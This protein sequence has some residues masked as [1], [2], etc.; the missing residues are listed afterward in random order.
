MVEDER[1]SSNTGYVLPLI[2]WLGALLALR[3]AAIHAATIDLVPDEAQYWSWSQELSFGYFSKPPMIAWLIRGATAVCG[4]GA[5]CIRSPSSVLYTL[6]SAMAFLTGRAL[7][8][9]RVG[10]WSAVVFDTLPGL[11]YSSLL[12]TTDVPL[13]L[14][15]TVALYFWV[16][17][18]KRQTMGFAVLFGIAVGLGLLTKQ[19]M[20][21]AFLCVACHALISR[22]ARE[23]LKG[24]RGLIAVFV[25]LA[26]LAPNIVWNAEHGF[27]TVRHTGANI[28]WQYPYIHPLQ[29]LDYVLVQFGVFGPILVV[30]L[31]RTAWREI[32]APGDERKALLLCFSLPVLA[33]L[34]V[35]AVLSRTH[36]N[37]SA[38]AYPA[39]TILVTAVLLELERKLLFAVSLGLH[40]AIAVL[41]AIAPAFARQWPLFERV[42]FL[43]QAVGWRSAADAVRA[44]LD[45]DRY[46]ALL[47]DTRETAAELLY[48]LRDSKVPLYVWRSQAAPSNHYEMTR[49]YGAG[50]PEPVL[51][52][53][54]RSCPPRSLT[55]AFAET[56]ELGATTVPLVKDKARVLHFC[57]LAGYKGG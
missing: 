39:A 53:S 55:Q 1:T 40:L 3:L 22:E 8:N 5:V 46:G 50:A 7:F 9:A 45:E 12:I 38:T 57:R 14:F 36:G 31:I 43:S 13:I 37:W 29:L 16:M 18:V 19:A 23:A 33:I 32:T 41:L 27:P 42:Q 24:G 48:Y 2:A 6:A 30:V 20:L 15:W 56:T 21:Y 4:D 34:T 35:Q 54:L 49:A 51:F 26:L 47:L 25:A 11:S 52:V 44:K 10:F 17:L 28:G